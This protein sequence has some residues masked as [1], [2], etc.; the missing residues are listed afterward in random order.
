[1]VARVVWDHEAA[2][3]SPVTS[4]PENRLETFVSRRLF[5]LYRKLYRTSDCPGGSDTP[6]Q[7]KRVYARAF[8]S[9]GFLTLR[10]STVFHM[11]V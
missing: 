9:Y 3:S 8:N 4:I 6:I 11:R 5:L 1:M 7:K 10:K 2:G